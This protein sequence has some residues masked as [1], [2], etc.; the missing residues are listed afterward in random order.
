MHH[1]NPVGGRRGPHLPCCSLVAAVAVKGM[2]T[3]LKTGQTYLN[4]EDDF[5][6]A[7]CVF[8]LGRMFSLSLLNIWPRE[9]LRMTW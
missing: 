7:A 9:E 8:C 3:G 2:A 5:P 4:S 1:Q 6:Q